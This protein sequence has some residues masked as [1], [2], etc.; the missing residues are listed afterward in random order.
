MESLNAT[1]AEAIKTV[2]EQQQK[3]PAKS[4]VGHWGTARNHLQKFLGEKGMRIED[5]TEQD[6]TQKEAAVRIQKCVRLFLFYLQH[7]VKAKAGVGIA[8]VATI[9]TYAEEA[10]RQVGKDLEQNL[11]FTQAEILR[12]LVKGKQQPTGKVERSP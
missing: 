11:E 2:E 3:A 8:P 6:A 4:T 5:I 10:F 9:I 12:K 1:E 7:T